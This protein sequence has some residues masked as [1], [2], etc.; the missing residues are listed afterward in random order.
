MTTFRRIGI[1]LTC[2]SAT[3][4][5][6]TVAT[7]AQARPVESQS[8]SAFILAVVPEFGGPTSMATLLCDPAGGTH[9]D[10]VAACYVLRIAGGDFHAIQGVRG[11]CTMDYRPVTAIAYGYWRGTPTSYSE[12]FTN[13]CLMERATSGVFNF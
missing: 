13:P 12:T 5:G 11:P 4:A 9:P 10:P 2:L 7:P 8:A 3:A 1:A 6:L